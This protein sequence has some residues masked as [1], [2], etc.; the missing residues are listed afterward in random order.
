MLPMLLLPGTPVIIAVQ[1]LRLADSRLKL[2]VPNLTINLTTSVP[3]NNSGT[4]S[5]AQCS[6][7]SSSSSGKSSGNSNDPKPKN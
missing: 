4:K 3:T 2:N 6:S 5:A 1:G 7:K